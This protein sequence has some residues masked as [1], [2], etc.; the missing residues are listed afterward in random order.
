MLYTSYSKPLS[1]L[2]LTNDGALN[3]KRLWT[4]ASMELLSGQI[5]FER[6]ST[7]TL[8]QL[9]A[10]HTSAGRGHRPTRIADHGRGR[11]RPSTGSQPRNILHRSIDCVIMN[12]VMTGHGKRWTSIISWKEPGQKSPFRPLSIPQS[13]KLL[14]SQFLY[15]LPSISDF[16]PL[17]PFP[18]LF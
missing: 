2:P 14:L 9:S 12:K 3:P 18:L 15:Q 17:F 1:I 16:H 13:L 5:M 4:A 6:Q 7:E 11:N 8:F 10:P